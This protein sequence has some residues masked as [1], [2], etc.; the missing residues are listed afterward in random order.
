[1]GY[2]VR[3]AFEVRYA[4]NECQMKKTKVVSAETENWRS[5]DAELAEQ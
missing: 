2:E 4:K 5:C 1:K 3:R